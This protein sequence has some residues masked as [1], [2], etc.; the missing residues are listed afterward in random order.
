MPV[1]CCHNAIYHTSD[2][3]ILQVVSDDGKKVRRQQPFTELDMEELQVTL[4]SSIWSH[5]ITLFTDC[6]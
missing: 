5:F 4:A 2:M 3:V 1:L 6:K